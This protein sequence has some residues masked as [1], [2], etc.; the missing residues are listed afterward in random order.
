MKQDITAIILTFNESLH[1]SR[2]I[3]SLDGFVHDVI[4]VDSFST[5]DTKK[6]AKDL[7]VRFYQNAWVNYADQFQ[8]ALDYG[9]INTEW[10][11]RIDADEYIE[12]QLKQEIIEVLPVVQ[13]ETNGF[14]VKRKYVFLGQW[15]RHGAMYP[16]EVLRLWRT[17]TGRI[18]Q[19]WMDEHIVLEKGNAGHL[20]GNIVDENINNIDWFIAKHN[21]Y[22]TREMID[23]LNLKYNFLE[24]D[25]SMEQQDAG[26][27]K[28][29][30][31]LKK[32][33]YVKLPYFVRP[34]L[35]F[36]YR[37]FFKLGF[38]DGIKGFAYHFMQ[39]YWYRSLVDLKMLEAE[40]WIAK[41]RDPEVIKSILITKT[42]LKL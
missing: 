13:P 11:L 25:D 30:R 17:G 26:Q 1:L 20:E 38:L 33:F 40:G 8:W 42:G 32:S 6:I 29:K 35:Y 5:D 3:N 31:W 34:F 27:A 39:G 4:V 22:A 18:E 2:C 21:G 41:E 16:I 15:I 7:G 24:F 28:V 19:R 36:L 37:Y 12:N 14:Y 10:V 9:E 23:L